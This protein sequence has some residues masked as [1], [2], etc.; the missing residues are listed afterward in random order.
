[1]SGYHLGEDAGWDPALRRYRSRRSP[2]VSVVMHFNGGKHEVGDF[3]EALSGRHCPDAGALRGRCLAAAAA[4]PMLLTFLLGLLLT[5]GLRA[6]ALRLRG[7][8]S[9]VEKREEG[10][11][12][13]ARS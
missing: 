5:R 8:P 3:F 10:A 13:G 2:G 4:A 7:H 6:L 9:G 1:M 12:G 11:G